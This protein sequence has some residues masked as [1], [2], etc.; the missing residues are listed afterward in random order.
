MFAYF[1]VVLPLLRFSLSF[2]SRLP[3]MDPCV[4][5]VGYMGKTAFFPS[6]RALLLLQRRVS[7]E[8]TLIFG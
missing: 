5:Q 6:R 3:G 2:L 8:K 1:S 4:S 7:F